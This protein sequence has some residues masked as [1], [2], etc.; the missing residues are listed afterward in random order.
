[1]ETL[2]QSEEK[3]KAIDISKSKSQEYF[4]SQVLGKDEK[5]NPL[6]SEKNFDELQED[7]HK[8]TGIF[9][10]FTSALKNYIGNKVLTKEDLK[11][12]M[13]Q[14]INLLMEKMRKINCRKFM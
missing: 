1:M 4:N 3:G 10:K 11:P 12:A 7:E 6:F 13:D 9:S 5:E 8:P 14:L 2:D